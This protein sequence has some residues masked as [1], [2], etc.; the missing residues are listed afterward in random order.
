M[1]F[2]QVHPQSTVSVLAGFVHE[3]FKI[4]C[5][6]VDNKWLGLF[7][8]LLWQFLFL[9]V[10]LELFPLEILFCWSNFHM[11][12]GLKVYRASTQIKR[13]LR[14]HKKFTLKQLFYV[15]IILALKIKIN[16]HISE[17]AGLFIFT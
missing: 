13:F 6:L 16:L 5:F 14:S 8:D 12:P 2:I 15:D 7:L 17:K 10:H 11:T 3:S 4:Q 9:W 1:A